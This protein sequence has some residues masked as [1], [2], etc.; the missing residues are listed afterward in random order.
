MAAYPPESFDVGIFPNVNY[1]YIDGV[2]GFPPP[3]VP[4]A[5]ALLD[6]G[7]K[8]FIT[9]TYGMYYALDPAAPYSTY[10][11]GDAQT[12]FSSRL[13]VDYV[14]LKGR[15]SGNNPTQTSVTGI[16]GDPVGNGIS[17][18]ASFYQTDVFTIN[19]SKTTNPVIYLDNKTSTI[20][21]FRYDNG[22]GQRAVYLD[23]NFGLV[24]GTAN[25]TG[26]TKLMSQSM[27]FLVNGISSVKT[28]DQAT[29]VK[30]TNYPNPVSKNTT[31]N[32]SLTERG[33]VNLAI[34]DVL[35]RQVSR[36]VSNETEDLGTYTADFDASHL[37]AGSYTYILTSGT[38]KVTGTMTVTK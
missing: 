15:S 9:S 14:A 23:M 1:F 30:I 36:L 11:N 22:S 17:F 28:S 29:S 12:F 3:V 32:Y 16:A 34:Y 5:N 20:G 7:K 33:T 6:A 21:G 4:A 38:N 26:A 27:D 31:F 25:V 2:D 19:N 35:G 18:K 10:T 8:V 37:A 24:S 13:G